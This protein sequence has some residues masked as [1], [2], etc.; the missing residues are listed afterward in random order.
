MEETAATI[1]DA[2][3]GLYDSTKELSMLCS[4]ATP[5]DLEEVLMNL[6]CEADWSSILESSP[7][8]SRR[9][10]PYAFS[11]MVLQVV[12]KISGT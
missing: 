6:D 7:P 4:R 12:D 10:D 2:S 3:N 9:Q 1:V 11:P 5:S 8:P